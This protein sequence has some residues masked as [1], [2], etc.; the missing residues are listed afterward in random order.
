MIIA[1][2]LSSTTKFELNHLAAGFSGVYAFRAE[3]SLHKN[4]TVVC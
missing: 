2:V 1:L 3:L 4:P